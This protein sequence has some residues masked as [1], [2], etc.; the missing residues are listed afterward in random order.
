MGGSGFKTRQAAAI[1]V[2]VWIYNVLYTVPLAVWAELKFSK[3]R[4]VIRC[5]TGDED[6]NYLLASR[7]VN[8]FVPLAITWASYIGIIYK[9]KTSINKANL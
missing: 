5:R 3:K 6:V 7:S 9:L 4:G 8:F 2:C 1:V